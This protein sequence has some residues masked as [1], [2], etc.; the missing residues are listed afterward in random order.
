MT[1]RPGLARLRALRGGTLRR[2][3]IANSIVG[4]YGL[5]AQILLLPLILNVLPLAEYGR[6]APF[7][8]LV[9]FAAVAD[10]GIGA[11]FIVQTA[12]LFREGRTADIVSF[13]RAALELY[14]FAGVVALGGCLGAS[15]MLGWI[16][17]TAPEIGLATIAGILGIVLPWSMRPAALSLHAAQ[18][19][20]VERV[21]AATGTTA[22]VVAT[23]V[24]VA[25]HPSLMAFAVCD[26]I[27]PAVAGV[28]TFAYMVSSGRLSYARGQHPGARRSL[29]E[30][31]VRSS[32]QTLLGAAAVYLNPLL[33]ASLVS[34][35]R[36]GLYAAA[37]RASLA[38]R[39]VLVWISEPLLPAAAA[40]AQDLSRLRRLHAQMGT[41]C[42]GVAGSALL[43]AGLSPL[44]APLLLGA[45]V[46]RGGQGAAI[47]ALLLAAFA[48]GALLNPQW[49]TT[50][51]AGAPSAFVRPNALLLAGTALALPVTMK[52]AGPVVA[53]SVTLFLM[54]L[55]IP[56]CDGVTR[57]VL[58]SSVPSTW[59]TASILGSTLIV[60]GASFAAARAQFVVPALT[61]TALGGGLLLLQIYRQVRAKERTVHGG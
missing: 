60:A 31:G 29:R 50:T 17:G 33:A 30:F 13:Q 12:P 9:Q 51:A 3:V 24:V 39:Q 7:L 4:V 61:L 45:G 47:L 38:A 46:S 25:V 37:Y 8:A 22:R 49:V 34:P 58:G 36:V 28:L 2:N 56:I 18:R 21:L 11:S 23:V 14:L 20:E 55:F 42:A 1:A 19:F 44:L 40:Q 15:L 59:S 32:G 48:A 27:A 26:V 10:A 43:I 53:A 16:H 5:G 54:L 41:V 35:A 52:W 6:W 57:R